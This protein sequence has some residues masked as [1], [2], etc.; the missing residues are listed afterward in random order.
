MSG[1]WVTMMQVVCF[2]RFISSSKFMISTVLYV[3][4]S[5]VGSS[6]ERQAGE[7]GKGSGERGQ[8]GG[9]RRG[10]FLALILIVSCTE[11]QDF[12]VVG[13]CACDRSVHMKNRQRD[14]VLQYQHQHHQ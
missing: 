8:G 1:L 11:Q 9:G 14:P 6:G 2:A 5:P 7:G 10:Q 12:R 4:R 13:E 3:S